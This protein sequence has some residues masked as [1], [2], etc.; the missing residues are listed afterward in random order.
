MASSLIAS[1]AFGLVLL[2][3]LVIL[4]SSNSRL[5]IIAL[6]LQYMGVMLL[7][8]FSWSLPLAAVKL[9]AGWMAGVLLF[10]SRGRSRLP[11]ELP[12]WPAEWLFR[13]VASVMVF[14]AVASFVPQVVTALPQMAVLQ[15]WGGL[16]LIG[17]GL[18]TLGFSQ[19]TLATLLSLLTFL[20]GFEILYAVVE[21]STLVAGL[22]AFVNLGIALVGSYLMDQESAEVNP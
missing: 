18:L 4:G 21:E 20:S 19:R 2:T 22:L 15:A 12:R 7:I 6:A 16:T 11:A 17:M 14:L 13:L 9:V 8:S 5:R 3:S 1:L 10:I